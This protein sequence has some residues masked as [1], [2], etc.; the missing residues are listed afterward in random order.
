MPEKKKRSLGE[1]TGEIRTFARGI[2]QGKDK[3]W[4]WRKAI[5]KG[6]EAKEEF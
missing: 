4:M 3:T 2:K 6:G 1:T 5:R